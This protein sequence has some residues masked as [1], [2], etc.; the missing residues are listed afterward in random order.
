MGGGS[1]TT[2]TKSAPWKAAQPYLKDIMASAANLYDQ[3]PTGYTPPS[4]YTTGGIDAIAQ[5]AQDPNSLTGQARNT[6]SGLMDFDMSSIG[7]AMRSQVMPAVNS[8]FQSAGRSG[9]PAHAGTMSRE[10]TRALAP[11]QMQARDQAMRASAMAPGL[12]YAD[13]DRLYGAGQAQDMLA[14]EEN[15]APWQRLGQYSTFGTQMGRMGGTSKQTQPGQSPFQ[16]AAGLGLGLL[17]L[18]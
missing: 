17:G 14:R 11:Y 10:M 7:D 12:Q 2:T 1:Q 8:T 4:A 18:F 5:T 3:D 13:A 16:T 15:Q 6:L 9:S